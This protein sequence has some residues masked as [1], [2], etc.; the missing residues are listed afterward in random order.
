MSDEYV[1][2]F[3]GFRMA[4]C[5]IAI[6]DTPVDGVP[7]IQE[8]NEEDS[9]EYNESNTPPHPQDLAWVKK[10]AHNCMGELNYDPDVEVVNVWQLVGT[11]TKIGPTN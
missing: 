6:T 1:W 10:R 3:S 9:V 8:I 5:F 7:R 4:P 2:S 11:F